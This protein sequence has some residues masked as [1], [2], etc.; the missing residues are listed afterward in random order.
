MLRSTN[1]GVS[2]LIA[3]DGSIMATSPQFKV[4]VL[5]GSVQPMRGATPYVIVG[6]WPFVA[7]VLVVLLLAGWRSRRER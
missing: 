5:T 2:A 4:H 7:S 6:D 3:A 1:T